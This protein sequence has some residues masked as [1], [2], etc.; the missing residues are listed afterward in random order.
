MLNNSSL[1]LMG[2]FLFI[3]AAVTHTQTI[4]LYQPALQA[5][6]YRMLGCMADAEDAVQEAYIKWLSIDTTKIENTK[7]YLTKMVTNAC[8]N[9]IQTK[10]GK[11]SMFVDAID[12][13]EDQQQV[14]QVDSFDL[15]NQLSVAWKFLHRK[16]EPLE[17]T[18]F[19][20]REVFNVEYQDLQLIVDKKADN[21]RKIVSRAKE[22][23]KNAELP[24]L[25]VS[26]PDISLPES[27]KSACQ[28]GSLSNLIQE[29]TKD[30]SEK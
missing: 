24:K 28:K 27:F 7:A 8:L 16:L 9:V 13:I 17:R 15:E 23:L 26:M 29:F 20:L 18:V 6:A 25:K 10:N 12:Q 1:E 3:F 21:C 2:L 30:F 14:D 19:V 22:K 4:Y 5:I 11:N